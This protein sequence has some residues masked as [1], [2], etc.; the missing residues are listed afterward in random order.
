MT[1]LDVDREPPTEAMSTM[2]GATTAG[3]PATLQ[4]HHLHGLLTALGP[5]RIQYVAAAVD[6][7]RAIP[8]DSR[9]AVLPH[10]L[11]EHP[12]LAAEPR[13]RAIADELRLEI[14]GPSNGPDLVRW[15]AQIS[16]VRAT[17]ATNALDR[18]EHAL[19][20]LAAGLAEVIR[21][22]RELVEECGET[23]P[24]D[25]PPEDTSELLAW[26][27]GPAATGDEDALA[28]SS[29]SL[30][31]HAMAVVHAA[32]EAANEVLVSEDV[33]SIEERAKIPR[34]WPSPFREA[35]LWSRAVLES[36]TRKK[37]R[38]ERSAR[39]DEA[40]ARAYFAHVDAERA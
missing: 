3:A 18:I 6:R 11:R 37:R 27:L 12:A 9:R 31:E 29:A 33:V 10:L 30:V 35:A 5:M 34:W 22:R 16:G 7:L 1:T 39:Y 19:T 25:S 26:A 38:S 40:F 24:L 36:G 23:A 28:R 14:E 13:V 4:L 32:R 21:W 17:S 8:L 20:G 2:E 15:L